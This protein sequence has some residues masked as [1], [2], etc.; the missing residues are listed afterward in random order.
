[1]SVMMVFSFS[2]HVPV[3]AMDCSPPAER[4]VSLSS[5]FGERLLV[6]IHTGTWRGESVVPLPLP[7]DFNE[8]E[9]VEQLT[10]LWDRAPRLK[11]YTFTEFIHAGSS[12][13]VF[14]VV[15]INTNSEWAIKIARKK[16]FQPPQPRK[17]LFLIPR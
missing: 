9:E 15:E 13:M 1:M 14:R 5:D 6:Y 8:A 11:L 3:R 17:V 16:E 12:G 4:A 7:R 2:R 10:I